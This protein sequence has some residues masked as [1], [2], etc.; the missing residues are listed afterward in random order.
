MADDKDRITKISESIRQL[1]D[2]T[3]RLLDERR[4]LLAKRVKDRRVSSLT[5]KLSRAV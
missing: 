2:D 3:Q 4:K 5:K 1:V